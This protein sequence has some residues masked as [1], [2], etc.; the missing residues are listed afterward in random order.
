MSR[1][2]VRARPRR[3]PQR[4]GIAGLE[5]R[6][7]GLSALAAMVFAALLLAPDQPQAQAE[8]CQRHNGAAACRIW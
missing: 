3:R 5:R 1:A 8:I 6:L 2:P 7:I 4:L